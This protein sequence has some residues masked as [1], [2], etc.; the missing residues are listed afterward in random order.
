[1]PQKFLIRLATE[2]TPD[3]EYILIKVR[4]NLNLGDYAVID[5]TYDAQNNVSNLNRH[6]FWFPPQEVNVNDFVV[7]YTGRRGGRKARWNN[8]S[9][10]IT[11]AFYWGNDHCIWNDAAD[12]AAILKVSVEASSRV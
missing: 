10:T 9:G 4:E 2:G 7:L 11:W 1:M 8:R 5:S 3:Q 6:I 12:V